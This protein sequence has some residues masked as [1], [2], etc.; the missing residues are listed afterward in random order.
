[1]YLK[2]LIL[3]LLIISSISMSI[4]QTILISQEYLSR[5]TFTNV[6]ASGDVS[7]IC[8]RKPLIAVNIDWRYERLEFEKFEID[9]NNFQNSSHRLVSNENVKYSK[10]GFTELLFYIIIALI[11][12]YLYFRTMKEEISKEIFHQL[13]IGVNL[14]LYSVA[15]PG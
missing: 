11:I 7:R 5:E 8:F 6:R 13:L 3:I 4:C 2:E 14:D 9:A 10:I 15:S 12:S 1:M